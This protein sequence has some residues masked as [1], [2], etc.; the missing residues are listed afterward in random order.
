MN[1]SEEKIER[2]RRGRRRIASNKQL[3]DAEVSN[4][5]EVKELA[6]DRKEWRKLQ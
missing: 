4:Y 2:K 1:I 3:K 6:M 5:K